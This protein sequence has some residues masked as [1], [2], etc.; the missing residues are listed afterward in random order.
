M[1]GGNESEVARPEQGKTQ[2]KG[3]KQH[4]WKAEVATPRNQ[5]ERAGGAE[6]EML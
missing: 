6:K 3:P 2:I 5:R 1:R 4:S